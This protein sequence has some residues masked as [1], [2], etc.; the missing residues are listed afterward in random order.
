MSKIY[1][2]MYLQHTDRS[3]GVLSG[4]TYNVILRSFYSESRPHSFK[5]SGFTLIELLVVVLIIGILAAVALPQYETAVEKARQSEAWGILQSI[6]QANQR[7]L[8]ANGTYTKD[9]SDL[10]ISF[11]LE[12]AVYNGN[13]PAKKSKYFLYA[14]SNST[15]AQRSVALAVRLNDNYSMSVNLEGQKVC[16]VEDG[17]SRQGARLC[18]EWADVLTDGR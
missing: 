11:G 9:I 17:V 14:A 18:E 15:G 2:K 1:Q 8:M 7:Y 10:D 16:V 4:F 6:A 5:R 3:Q 13:I 12:D